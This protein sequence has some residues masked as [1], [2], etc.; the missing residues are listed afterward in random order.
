MP[1]NGGTGS[2]GRNPQHAFPTVAHSSPG[3]DQVKE[4]AEKK[5]NRTAGARGGRGLDPLPCREAKK[6]RLR[7]KKA[8]ER[9][10]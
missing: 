7:I 5:Q 1:L 9:L 8:S 6:A 3:G 4:P 10:A 2:R